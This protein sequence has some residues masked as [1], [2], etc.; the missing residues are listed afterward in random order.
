[1]PGPNTPTRE[2][3]RLRALA[4]RYVSPSEAERRAS[5]A[6]MPPVTVKR[7][8]VHATSVLTTRNQERVLS[9]DM[10]PLVIHLLAGLERAGIERAVV[11]LGQEAAQV[12]EC[13]TACMG[14]QGSN[15]QSTNCARCLDDVF[16]PRCWQTASPCR[17]T[18]CT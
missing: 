14:P 7:A 6:H 16:A 4:A 10:R 1:M 9:V 3:F 5:M 8:L 2:S 13:V 15:P 18:L 12:A 17:S 11:T